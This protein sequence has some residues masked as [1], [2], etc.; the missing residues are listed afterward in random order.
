MW[1]N[2]GDRMGHSWRS[3]FWDSG[4]HARCPAAHADAPK[5][6]GESRRGETW[7]NRGE[8]MGK[9]WGYDGHRMVR[10]M[11]WL[12][13]KFWK[14]DEV[15]RGYRI[16]HFRGNQWGYDGDNQQHDSGFV[17]DF[18][19]TKLNRFFLEIATPVSNTPIWRDL[20]HQTMATWMDIIDRWWLMGDSTDV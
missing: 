6:P 3:A 18:A 7:R 10:K 2:H 4:P 17:W 12:W 20:D 5:L 9:P 15:E 1:S 16:N 14:T 13:V 8:T 11:S 19:T